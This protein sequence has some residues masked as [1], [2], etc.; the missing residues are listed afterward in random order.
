MEPNQP[1]MPLAVVKFL[2]LATFKSDLK[3]N[4]MRQLE[5]LDTKKVLSPETIKGGRA[6]A[7]SNEI[8]EGDDGCAT[9]VHTPTHFAD[10]GIYVCDHKRDNL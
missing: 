10:P 9:R 8:T 6:A 7:I 2:L 1:N 3:F 5:K 4:N